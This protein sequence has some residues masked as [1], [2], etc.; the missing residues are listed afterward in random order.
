M[1]ILFMFIS[2]KQGKQKA[3]NGFASLDTLVKGENF[4][5]TIDGKQAGL[6]TLKNDSGMVVKIT[7]YG[8]HIV[9]V[10]VP[11]KNGNYA[12]VLLGYSGID[13]YLK[14]SS[15]SGAIV[16]RYANRI[17]KGKF[18]L[19][20]KEYTLPLNNGPNSLHGGIKGFDKVVWNA[21]QNGDSLLLS[22]ISQDKEEGYPGKVEAKVLYIL[23]K[24]NELKI[25]FE[26]TTD[27]PTVINL[28]THG[29]FNLK[30][31][32]NGDILDQ[33]LE[34]FAD[35]ITSVDETMIPTGKIESVKGTPFDFTSPYIIGQRIND[36]NEQLKFGSGYD[37]NWVLNNKTGE[38]ALGVR[39]RDPKSGRVMEVY[40]TEP[41][42]QF[43]STNFLMGF[44]TGK[45]GKPLKYRNG[46]AFEPQHYPDS[47]NHDNFPSTIVRPG[48][49]YKSETIYK[50]TIR[51]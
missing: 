44:H 2:C 43:Y 31:E 8:A 29:Y 26:A 5:K 9:S 51:K 10:L 15:Y 50:F 12:D 45:S 24:D 39:L 47:P 17:A 4:Q 35:S 37:H 18:K 30:G 13:G 25:E 32:G 3:D 42:V 49:T 48:K 1:S 28:S 41:G 6:Y 34:I 38:L 16:G 46:A 14:D 21:T 22:Y 33:E 19:D 23:T 27:K 36:K 40:T 20:G 11:D 7:N